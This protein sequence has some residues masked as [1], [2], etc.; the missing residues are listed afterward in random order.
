MKRLIL[1]LLLLCFL[2]GCTLQG[3]GDYLSLR[4]HV[5]QPIS[6]PQGEP[7][8]E[9]T[10]VRNRTELRGAILS[11]IRNWQE[12]GT[13]QI[14]EYEGD[15]ESDLNEALLYA[16][17]KDPVGAYSV[18]YAD[19]EIIEEKG[20]TYVQISIVFRRSAA[21]TNAIIPVANSKEV[22]QK[23]SE[24]LD[25]FSTSLTLR[26]RNY[27]EEDFS[28]HILN[29]CMENPRKVLAIPEFSA[30]LYPE[31]GSHRILELHFSYPESKESMRS[32]L[33][34]MQTLFQ[35]SAIHA[36][37]GQT[38][39]E[40]A[41][42]LFRYL[43]GRSTAYGVTGRTPAMPAYSLLCDKVAHDL[44]FAIVFHDRCKECG[45]R[46]SIVTGEKNGRKYYWNLLYLDGVA[47]H[48]DLFRSVGLGEQELTLLYDEDLL[49]EGYLWD[50]EST[51]AIPR[52]AELSPTE[53]NPTESQAPTT[54]PQPPTEPRPTESQ[55]TETA[56]ESE[57][58]Q[59]SESESTSQEESTQPTE[60]TTEEASEPDP[61]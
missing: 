38:Q 12:I 24:A 20:T 48:V 17:R 16:T 2:C 10:L 19:G 42:N 14:P 30:D 34:S 39:A 43:T 18:D 7:S 33:R 35:S 40:R 44:S 27:T 61:S 54:E 60:T 4:P 1:C 22:L 23:I 5:E 55:T 57:N 6:S 52:P 28:A 29:Y 45:L 46:S 21:E 58:T 26:I 25:N 41:E 36:E 3:S 56:T 50:R 51:P 32:K 11:L 37:Q 8:Q 47:Y 53:P 9:P 49:E 31:E 13:L 15:P 59:A